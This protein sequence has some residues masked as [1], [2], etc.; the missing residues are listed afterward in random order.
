M[1]FCHSS[2]LPSLYT[3]IYVNFLHFHYYCFLRLDQYYLLVWRE[4][5]KSDK[6][7]LKLKNVLYDIY[8]KCAKFQL[9]T[10]T[11]T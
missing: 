4:G 7:I 1:F 6:N 5:V 11:F 2:P 9:N 8:Y 10:Y 3:S